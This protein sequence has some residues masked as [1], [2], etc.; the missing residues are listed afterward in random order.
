M[1]FGMPCLVR[2][3][4]LMVG[5]SAVAPAAF[6]WDLPNTGVLQ[7]ENTTDVSSQ[8]SLSSDVTLTIAPL[9]PE[10][11]PR[12]AF[13]GALSRY[14]YWAD[15][16][17][18]SH[19]SG[20]DNSG[21]VGFGYAFVAPNFSIVASLGPTFTESTQR[22]GGNTPSTSSSGIGVKYKISAIARP[23]SEWLLY[24]QAYY[25][26]FSKQ[27]LG[28]L[29]VGYAVVPAIYVGPEL[30][31]SRIGKNDQFRV[32]AQVTGFHLGPVLMSVSGGLVHDQQ[33]GGGAYVATYAQINF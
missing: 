27:Y 17:R 33:L 22:R 11:G 30:Q 10:S 12:V 2:S 26:S 16:E 8:K 6:A 24:S 32:G 3:T 5:S 13:T 20:A 28:Q 4:L 9:G 31:F 21:E 19:A 14:T 25:S 29:K 1:R 18:R 15:P 7:L 23:S